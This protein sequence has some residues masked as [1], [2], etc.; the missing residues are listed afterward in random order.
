MNL[1]AD[2]SEMV[3]NST[4]T[5]REDDNPTQE[6]EVKVQVEENNTGALPE[7]TV[8]ED[9]KGDKSFNKLPRSTFSQNWRQ[10][11]WMTEWK[12]REKMGIVKLK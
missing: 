7:N 6:E 11:S 8:E 3:D 1:L 5:P 2:E 9:N 4:Q 10:R 12:A